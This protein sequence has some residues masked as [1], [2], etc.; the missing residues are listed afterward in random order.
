MNKSTIQHLLIQAR[1]FFTKC[2]DQI[3]NNNRQR[4]DAE[5]RTFAKGFWLGFIMC[6]C[7]MIY[8]FGIWWILNSR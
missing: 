7:M 3:M 4:V 2:Y 8:M 5:Q 6:L 1:Y